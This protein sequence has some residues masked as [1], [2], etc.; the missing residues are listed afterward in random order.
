MSVRACMRVSHVYANLQLSMSVL[1]S[2][3]LYCVAIL[4]TVLSVCVRFCASTH[5]WVYVREREYEREEQCVCV[6]VC[7]GKHILSVCLYSCVC[8]ALI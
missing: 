5:A 7:V 3:D 2:A 4:L 6:C 8:V 1:L